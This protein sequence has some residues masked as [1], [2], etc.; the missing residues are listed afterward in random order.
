[1]PCSNILKYSFCA[2]KLQ[3]NSCF[4]TFFFTFL[5]QKKCSSII[6]MGKQTQGD[7]D[8][9]PTF[10]FHIQDLRNCLKSWL[11][12]SFFS[13]LFQCNNVDGSLFGGYNYFGE[14]TT[15]KYFSP[16]KYFW[17]QVLNYHHR[18]Q[19]TH[20]MPGWVQAV[21]LQWIPWILCMS[22]PGEEITFKSI[23]MTQ[24]LKV[25]KYYRLQPSN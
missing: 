5:S 11:N 21:F 22:R 18:L 16:I 8:L 2:K 25:G 19:E 3:N 23:L 1:M 15:I 17:R 12:I 14:T 24:K 10:Y 7:K 13:N 20:E 9:V 6:G 4:R